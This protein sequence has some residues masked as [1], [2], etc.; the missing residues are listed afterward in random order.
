ML[1]HT[2]YHAVASVSTMVAPSLNE[3]AEG[4]PTA[5]AKVGRHGTKLFSQLFLNF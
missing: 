3:K 5:A 1:Y 2:H 4:D